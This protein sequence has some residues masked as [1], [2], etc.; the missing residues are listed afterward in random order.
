MEA[1]TRRSIAY[2]LAVVCFLVGVVCYAAFPEV[3][4]SEPVRIMFDSSAG[5]VLFNHR[6]HMSE[7][8]YGLDCVS[9][10]HEDEDDPQSCSECHNEEADVSRADA[11][12]GQCRGCHEEEDA[13]PVQCSECHMM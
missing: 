8:G 11:L 10:H 3:E 6:G 4:P 5:S 2:C 7:S 12:H 1:N 9:C 13:G